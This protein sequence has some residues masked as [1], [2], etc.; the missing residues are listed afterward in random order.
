MEDSSIHFL[1]LSYFFRII[2][3]F[4]TGGRTSTGDAWADL[5]SFAAGVWVLVTIL[6]F[7]IS[8]IALAVLIHSTIRML[9]AKRQE[10]P[11]YATQHPAIAETR[12]DHNR[13][14]HV[15]ELIES[16]HENDWRQAIIEADIMLDDLLSQ[17]GYHG[18]GVGEK[19]RAVDPARF[20]TL[21][22]AW[23]A[24][25]IRN[26]IAHQGSAFPLTDHIAYRTIRNYEAV[27]R[28]HGEI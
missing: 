16:P 13:W 2:Y 11:K 22:N 12:R 23:E 28:E 20:Q 14:A 5:L 25:K 7:V 6:A 3:D 8:V 27:M 15:M 19:L 18:I 4:L 10:A 24:H 17:L 9:E 1:N 26:E 21:Q